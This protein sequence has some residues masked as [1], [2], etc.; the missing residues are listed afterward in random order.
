MSVIKIYRTHIVLTIVLYILLFEKPKLKHIQIVF[1][2][3]G[4]TVL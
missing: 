3:F 1:P 2:S 4:L